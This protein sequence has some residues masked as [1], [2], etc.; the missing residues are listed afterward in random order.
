LGPGRRCLP[1]GSESFVTPSLPFEKEKF[2]S[3]SFVTPSL[4][5]EKEKFISAQ[6]RTTLLEEP[7]EER[8]S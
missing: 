1:P 5:F 4:P 2:I 6:A 3:E 8:R 7:P